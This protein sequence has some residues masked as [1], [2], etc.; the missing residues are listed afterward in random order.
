MSKSKPLKRKK[1]LNLIK[2]LSFILTVDDEEI[3][4][5]SIESVIEELKDISNE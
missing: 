2:I 1:L 3:I 4:K 5:S